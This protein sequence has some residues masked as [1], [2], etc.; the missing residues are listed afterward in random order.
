LASGA[1]DAAYIGPNPAINLFTKSNGEAIRVVSG[2]T[3]GGA[4]LVVRP[5]ITSVD[6]LRGTT[7]ATP[8][9]GNTQDVALRY[10]LDSNG[11]KVDTQGGG[12]LEV[13]PQDNSVTVDAY[14]SGAIDGAWVPEPTLSRLVADGATVLVDE[15]DEWPGGK[16]VTTHLIVRTE[17]LNHNPQIVRR[18][19]EANVASIDALNADPAAAQ[20]ATNAALGEITGKPLDEELV[21]SAWKNLTF[22]P[23]PIA[24][25]LFV[26]ADHALELGLLDNADLDGIYNLTA[27]NEV[28]VAA[29]KPEVADK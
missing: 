24:S 5:D 12:D 6:Q 28:L 27:L 1:L 26:S 4:A 19:V 3:S 16:F 13:R 18:L 11:I 9:L 22:T 17:Y 7:I 15:A 10:F 25:S 21:A 2:A 23:D 20:V 8:S 29:G 14:K